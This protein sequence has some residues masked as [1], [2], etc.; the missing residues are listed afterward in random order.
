MRFAK[1]LGTLENWVA[2]CARSD[3]DDISSDILCA[4]PW[5]IFEVETVSENASIIW[6]SMGSRTFPTSRSINTTGLDPRALVS[7][8]NFA[9]HGTRALRSG[10]LRSIGTCLCSVGINSG[11]MGLD[12]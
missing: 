9:A 5:S 4:V 7:K 6:L 8:I 11:G 10:R 2:F 1:I 3:R 12:S